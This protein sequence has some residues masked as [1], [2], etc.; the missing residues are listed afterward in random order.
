MAELPIEMWHLIFDHLQLAD[1]SSCARVSKAVYFAVKAYRI[2]EIAFTGRVHEWFHSTPTIDHKHRVDYSLASILKLSSFDFDYLKRL[3]IG[4]SSAI[5]LDDINRFV[6]LEELDISLKNNW[7]TRHLS[8]ASLK[9]LYVSVPSDIPYVKLDT[10]SLKK[11]HTYSLEKLE[12]IHPESVQCIHTFVHSGK[13]STFSNLEYLNITNYYNQDDFSSSYASRFSS[14]KRHNYATRF[15]Q[16]S[17]IALEKLKEIDFNYHD[18][19]VMKIGN[20]RETIANLLA[21][22]RPD[23]KVFW[24]NVQV[25]DPSLLTEYERTINNTGS[26]LVFQLQHYEMLKENEVF[27]DFFNDSIRVLTRAGFNPRSDEFLSKLLAKF[28]FRRI[29]MTY[30]IEEQELLLKL[31]ARSPSLLSLSFPDTDLGQSFFERVADTIRL[32]AIPLQILDIRNCTILNFE[33]VLRF[34]DLLCFRTDQQLPGRLVSKLFKL[35]MLTEIQF[36]FGRSVTIIGRVSPSR[37]LLNGEPLSKQELF[38]IFRVKS[39]STQCGLM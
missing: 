28:S 27:L 21:L 33:F 20:F 3:K 35:P 29:R 31:I 1:L 2:R 15:E 25:T 17:L 26:L 4:R 37:F 8:L 18:D 7:K 5:H 19:G 10:P 16:F 9:V 6:H 32:N 24:Q 22:D 34:R 39:G 13:L 12:F 23:L 11:V 36:T 38:E 30:Y 14:Y